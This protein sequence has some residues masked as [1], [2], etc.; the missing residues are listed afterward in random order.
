MAS[1]YFTN[2]IKFKICCFF[3]VALVLFTAPF[4]STANNTFPVKTIVID[5]GHGGKD[6]GASGPSGIAE[7]EVT[8][9]ISLKLKKELEK[10]K[11]FKVFMTRTTDKFVS[12]KKRKKIAKRYKPDVLISIHCDGNKDRD[13]NGTAVYILSK[14]GENFTIK[15]SLTQGDYVF[16]GNYMN[17][18]LADANHTM[19][20]T[21]KQS[22]KLADITLK[23]LLAQL[24]TKDMHVR[25]AGFKVLKILD[26]PSILIEVAFITNWWEEK[27]L[28]KD[29]F[30][31]KAAVGIRKA[32]LEFFKNNPHN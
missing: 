1:F 10:T 25:K 5:P 31:Q 20:K 22:R 6:Q 7:K 28:K 4:T 32:L 17:N 9:D 11:K 29:K 30:R 8:L 26:V 21:M 23:Y 18:S 2:S 19:A 15:R 24:G 12:L 27:Q 3:I 14:K 13:I 16:N